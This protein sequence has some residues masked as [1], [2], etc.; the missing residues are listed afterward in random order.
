MR[1]KE[2]EKDATCWPTIC[3]RLDNSL[4]ANSPLLPVKSYVEEDLLELSTSIWGS[5]IRS[6][7][8][9]AALLDL[10]FKMP[11]RDGKIY[12]LVLL[13]VLREAWGDKAN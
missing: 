9:T 10:I 13:L 5:G 1:H 8:E 4:L 6:D 2:V 7:T 11:Y 3:H 12:R